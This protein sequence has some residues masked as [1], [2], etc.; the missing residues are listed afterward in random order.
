MSAATC[1]CSAKILQ[2]KGSQQSAIGIADGA[3]KAA[4]RAAEGEREAAILRAESNRQ[5]YI[6]EAEGRA[7]AISSVYQSI[8]EVNPD[9]SLIAIL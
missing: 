9:P 6:L 4:I 2:S 3:A 1:A 5:A 7:Q 8:R